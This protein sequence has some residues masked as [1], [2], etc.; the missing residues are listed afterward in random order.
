MP[1]N[2]EILLISEIAS[3]FGDTRS[4]TVFDVGANTGSYSKA[5][6][7]ILPNSIIH[8]FEIL[9]NTRD[10]L[11]RYLNGFQNVS[12]SDCGLSNSDTTI[13]IGFDDKNDTQARQLFPV[14]VQKTRKHIIT[15]SVNTGDHYMAEHRIETIDLL[16]IDTEGH[17]ISVLQGFKSAL[18]NSRVR[19]IQFEYGSTWIA[20]SHF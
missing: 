6:R 2:G 5:V 12:I 20:P 18:E 1:K 4:L 13:E 3:S 9:P 17:E 11:I 8:C 19:V 7:A 16:K 15:C 14:A 10:T